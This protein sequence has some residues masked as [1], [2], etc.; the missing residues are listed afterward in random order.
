MKIQ[1][2]SSNNYTTSFGAKFKTTGCTSW[3]KPETLS[4]WEELAKNIG[5]D[6]DIVC[7]KF[8][9]PKRYTENIYGETYIMDRGVTFVDVFVSG[10][11]VLD[12]GIELKNVYSDMSPNLSP[13]TTKINNV[14]YLVDRY[15]KA[16]KD[17]IRK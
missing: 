12:G 14:K 1:R 6:N 8:G 13:R 15:L 3:I 16:L 7:L 17:D 2:N 9:K 11:V 10:K 4:G 5:R